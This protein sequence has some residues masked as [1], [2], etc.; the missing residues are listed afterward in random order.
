MDPDEER[1]PEF[2][3]VQQWLERWKDEVRVVDYSTGGWEHL[4]NVEGPVEAL[5]EVPMEIRCAGEWTD[6]DSL[7]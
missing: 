7:S 2:V 3:W 5:R 6:S 1:P 4:W